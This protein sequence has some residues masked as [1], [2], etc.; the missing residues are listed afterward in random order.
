MNVFIAGTDTEIGKTGATCGLLKALSNRGHRVAGMKPV[1]AGTT[2]DGLNPD[3]IALLRS[4]CPGLLYEWVNPCVFQAPTAPNIAADLEGRK[5]VWEAIEAAYRI[6]SANA[7][8]VVLEGIG[9][10]RVPLAPGLFASDI[11]KRLGLPVVLV[12]GIRLGAV[13]H[14]LLTAEAIERDGCRLLGWLANVIDPAYPYTMATIETLKRHI[15]APC[16]G[17]IP[18]LAKFDPGM[19]TAHLTALTDAIDVC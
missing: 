11:P 15:T 10:W 16:L 18:W 17:E 5:I 19:I 3:A 8:L 12:S 7:D 4:S 2:G 9:G 6:L 1:A 14:T 13:N